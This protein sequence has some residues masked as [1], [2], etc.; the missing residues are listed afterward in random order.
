M[1]YIGVDRCDFKKKNQQVRFV[2]CQEIKVI[3][4]TDEYFYFIFDSVVLLV[5]IP[6]F[7]G[8]FNLQIL[9]FLLFFGRGGGGGGA[10]ER[11]KILI[12]YWIKQSLSGFSSINGKGTGVIVV[13]EGVGVMVVCEGVGIMVVCEGVGVIVTLMC[14]W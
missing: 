7:I 9:F 10:I 4:I 1:F 6:L 3:N 11:L 2:G 14:K 8:F 12:S 13:C 5:F